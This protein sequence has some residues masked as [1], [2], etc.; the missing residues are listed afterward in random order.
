MNTNKKR[1]FTNHESR[2]ITNCFELQSSIYVIPAKLVPYSD[3]GAGIQ[4]INYALSTGFLVPPK[5]GRQ[6][7][8]DRKTN[9][10]VIIFVDSYFIHS[11]VSVFKVIHN[12]LF[13]GL[14]IV[15]K[16]CII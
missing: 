1:I 16:S 5:A 8:N 6:A 11:F 14:L 4:K 2:I 10:Q 15:L 12:R 13:D 7:R 3:T 9:T